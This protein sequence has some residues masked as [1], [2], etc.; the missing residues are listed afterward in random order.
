MYPHPT[1]GRLTCWDLIYASSFPSL[2]LP[3]SMLWILGWIV[4]PTGNASHLKV[5]FLCSSFP[6]PST[7]LSN[8]L[9]VCPST[10]PILTKLWDGFVLISAFCAFL[11]GSAFTWLLSGLNPKALLKHSSKQLPVIK[12]TQQEVV[13]WPEERGVRSFEFLI[14]DPCYLAF[15]LAAFHFSFVNQSFSVTFTRNCFIADLSFMV[16]S[17]ISFKFQLKYN[18]LK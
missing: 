3:H 11:P 9:H 6:A 18:V 2:L 4:L 1:V 7:H 10:P 16:S 13:T 5:Q 12:W 17:F 14:W 8:S 15:W